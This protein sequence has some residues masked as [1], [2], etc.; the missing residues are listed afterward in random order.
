MIK[1]IETEYLEYLNPLLDHNFS[2]MKLI[3]L[4]F[5]EGG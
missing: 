1:P 4:L 5:V 3:N 2:R